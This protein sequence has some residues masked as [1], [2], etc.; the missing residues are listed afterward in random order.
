[1]QVFEPMITSFSSSLCRK[2]KGGGKLS[3]FCT[4][5][6]NLELAASHGLLMD[7]QIFI[8]AYFTN[9]KNAAVF[10]LSCGINHPE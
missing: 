4:G 8:C 9:R 7:S 6:Q 3:V 1:M 10:P 5:S 2:K